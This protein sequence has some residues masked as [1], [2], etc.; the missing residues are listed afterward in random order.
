MVPKHS[1]LAALLAV[2]AA[3]TA[4]AAAAAAA[5][6]PTIFGAIRWDCWNGN[7]QDVISSTVAEVMAP[8]RYHWRL[9]W[10]AQVDSANETHVTFDGDEQS[11]MDAELKAASV[12][13]LSFWAYDTYCE[14][15]TDRAIPQCQGYWGKDPQGHGPTSLG[16]QARD[17][18]YGLKRHL[19]SDVKHLMNISLVLLGASPALPVMRARYLKIIKDEAFQTVLGGRPL[20]FLFQASDDE[21]AMNGGWVSWRAQWD[22]FR[23]ESVAQGSGDPYFV[24]MTVGADPSRAV[25]LRKHLGFDAVSAYAIPGGTLDG[26]PYAEQVNTTRQFWA[27]A[28]GLGEKLV[29]PVPTGWDPRPRGDLKNKTGGKRPIWVNEGDRHYMEPTAAELTGLIEDASAFIGAEPEVA[30]SGA[31]I[32]YAWNENTEGGWLIP[33]LGNGDQRIR[34]VAKALGK[35][36]SGTGEA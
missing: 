33:T 30:E 7:T 32:V 14:W 8:P 4:A 22:A 28:K 27:K 3:T 6:P 34:A 21:A 18:A 26:T 19:S 20:I 11:V 1:L 15:P 29:P 36:G 35:F 5:P 2:A 31:A 12:A 23:Q 25:S 9:P 10:Y 24:A 17:P 13:G 16:Y